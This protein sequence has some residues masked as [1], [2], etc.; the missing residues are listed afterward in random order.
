MR[1]PQS[2]P[3]FVLTVMTP[4]ALALPAAANVPSGFVETPIAGGLTRPTAMSFAP[5]GR[6]FVCQQTGQLR[7][8]KNGSLLATPFVTLSVDSNGERGLLGVTFD[9][10]FPTDPYV[11]VYYTTSSSPIHN[12]VSRFTANGDA[13][14]PGETII[15]DLENLSAAQNHNGGAIHFGPDGKL[16]VAVGENAK[17]ENAQLFTN[18]L[19]KMLRV[20]QD[21]TIPNDN[22]FL[23]QTTGANQAI[24]ALGLRNP[25]TFAFDPS[26]GRMFLNDVGE[27]TWEEVNEGIAGLNYGWPTCEGP[28]NTGVGT[29]TSASFR[30]PRFAYRHDSGTPQGCAIVGGAFYDPLLGHFPA[31]FAGDYLF[32][33]LCGGYVWR[34]DADLNANGAFVT[35]ITFPVD[36]AFGPDGDLYYLSR[37]SGTNT[38]AVHRVSTEEIFMDGFE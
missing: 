37:G 2:L 10:D 11:Y 8:I 18:R 16:Y 9:P 34:F 26:S 25:F 7:V 29:C 12:R 21:G 6:L 32:A 30:Y 27:I 33:D 4:L 19:G 38:G 20:N 22:P 3:R 28:Q 31:D 13:A 1:L 15:L 5:D 14:A 36:V 23:A 24:W 17:E 35:G